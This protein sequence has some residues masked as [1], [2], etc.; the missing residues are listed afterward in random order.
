[1]RRFYYDA[2]RVDLAS[3]SASLQKVFIRTSEFANINGRS[4]A[5]TFEKTD[6]PRD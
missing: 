2:I 5:S 4:C 1:M 3:L 6:M